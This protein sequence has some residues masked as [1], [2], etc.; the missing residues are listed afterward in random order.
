MAALQ[1]ISEFYGAWFAIRPAN[2]NWGTFSPQES[3]ISQ[4]ALKMGVEVP[5]L[6]YSFWGERD[7]RGTNGTKCEKYGEK[8][9]GVNAALFPSSFYQSCLISLCYPCSS[10]LS[11][12]YSFSFSLFFIVLFYLA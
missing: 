4:Q 2:Q 8:Y 11:G 12:I 6:K 3:T 9:S 5:G 1:N 7:I 10:C